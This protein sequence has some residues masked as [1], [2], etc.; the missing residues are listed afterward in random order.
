MNPITT[1]NCLN[2]EMFLKNKLDIEFDIKVKKDYV[3]VLEGVTVDK[4]GVFSVALA[5]HAVRELRSRE[6]TRSGRHR[7]RR[8]ISGKRM[9]GGCRSSTHRRN[10]RSGRAWAAIRSSSF[11]DRRRITER[12]LVKVFWLKIA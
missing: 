10:R 1:L 7:G 6:R 8:R 2:D 9:S 12:H 11:A 3:I 4:F 5:E